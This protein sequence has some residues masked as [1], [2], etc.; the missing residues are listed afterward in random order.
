MHRDK[1]PVSEEVVVEQKKESIDK[2]IKKSNVLQKEVK[3]LTN[4]KEGLTN[5]INEVFA[6]RDRELGE[7]LANIATMEDEKQAAIN[8]AKQQA[9]SLADDRKGF[10]EYMEKEEIRIKTQLNNNEGNRK[11]NLAA[12]D[13]NEREAVRLKEWKEEIGE[14]VFDVQSREKLSKDT[15]KKAE[16]EKNASDIAKAENE[17]IVNRIRKEQEKLEE[18]KVEIAKTEAKNISYASALEK[19]EKELIGRE[20]DCNGVKSKYANKE[21]AFKTDRADMA[22]QKQA[23]K[24]EANRLKNMEKDIL[25][26]ETK[27][28]GR[29]DLFKTKIGG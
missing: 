24:V 27:L 13:K 4:K 2:L 23:N 1:V 10:G 16:D 7:S 19:K 9:T 15:L 5:M 20:K 26:R 17:I 28:R 3:E 11:G 8:A 14:L 18:L 25:N 29:E 12:K 6:D 22:V 21:D